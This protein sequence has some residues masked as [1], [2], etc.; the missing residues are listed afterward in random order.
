MCLRLHHLAV[1]Y[2]CFFLPL[3][4]G[5]IMESNHHVTAI[6]VS[7]FYMCPQVPTGQI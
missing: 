2:E 5:L 6:L 3:C 7:G 4:F 1:L